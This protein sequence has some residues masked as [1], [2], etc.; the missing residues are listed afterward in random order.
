MSN[1]SCFSHNHFA[2][3]C[4]TFKKDRYNL[5]QL[6]RELGMPKGTLHNILKSAGLKGE[7]RS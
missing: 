2:A 6:E 4:D 7:L 5:S 3:A 1:Q